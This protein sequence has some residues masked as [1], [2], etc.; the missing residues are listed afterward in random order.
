MNK[1]DVYPKTAIWGSAPGSFPQKAL[2]PS[3]D[4]IGKLAFGH[5][6]PDWKAERKL[7]MGT[8]DR[9]PLDQAPAAEEESPTA[10]ACSLNFFAATDHNPD[11]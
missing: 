5:R 6:E 2:K 7:E 1:I 11:D 3:V 4:S 9:G 8:G 10:S